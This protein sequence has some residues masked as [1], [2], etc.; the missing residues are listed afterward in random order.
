MKRRRILNGLGT[1]GDGSAVDRRKTARER[2]NAR[3]LDPVGSLHVPLITEINPLCQENLYQ[4]EGKG[5]QSTVRWEL[6]IPGE[7]PCADIRVCHS[8]IRRPSKWII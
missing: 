7:K 1:S 8:Y 6:Q 3:Q 2:E 5:W 4:E